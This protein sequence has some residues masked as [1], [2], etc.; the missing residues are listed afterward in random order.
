M[1]FLTSEQHKESSPARMRRD[2]KD[3]QDL[4]HY[5]IARNPFNIDGPPSLRNIATG[6]VAQ[7]SVNCDSA[8]D[9]G[10][11][12]LPQMPGMTVNEHS[13]R[14]RDQV[15]SMDVKGSI[16]VKDSECGSPSSVPTLSLCWY[17]RK[18]VT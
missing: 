17:N 9:V 1:S 8:K 14:K 16:K 3:I 5:L 6:I 12:I 13:F 4:L 2:L 11:K 7:D 18:S 15:K 10:L